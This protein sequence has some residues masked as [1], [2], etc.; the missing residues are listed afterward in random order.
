M[1]KASRNKGAGAEREIVQ[2]LKAR[3]HEVRRAAYSGALAHEKG[4]VVGLD[5]LHME[6]KR[7][8]KLQ[9]PAWTRQAESQCKPDEIPA[10]IYRSSREPWRISIPFDRFMDLW[11][12]AN[13]EFRTDVWE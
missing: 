2:I 13:P 7:C 10:V 5:G 8:E 9:I 3:G 12:D 4:D 11:E 1:G 6:V